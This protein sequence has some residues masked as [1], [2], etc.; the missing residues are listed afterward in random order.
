MHCAADGV[1]QGSATADT[2][3]AV[4]HWLDLPEIHAVIDHFAVVAEQHCGEQRLARL[5]L[6]L[7][8]HGV[9]AADGVVLQP[10]HGAA[11][12]QNEDDFSQI[13]VHKNN[14]L[15]CFVTAS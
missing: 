9:E 10:G 11:A 1:Q 3:L 13:L 15:S 2:V 14:P 8:H 6:L 7:F 5:L 12:V 4:G